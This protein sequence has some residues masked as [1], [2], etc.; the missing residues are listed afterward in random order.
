MSCVMWFFFFNDTATTEIYTLSLP[1]ALPIL[2]VLSEPEDEL[3]RG[4]PLHAGTGADARRYDPSLVER[5][6][7]LPLH[8][9]LDL[10]QPRG[11]TGD[12]GGEDKGGRPLREGLL[13]R[14]RGDDRHRGGGE[15][16]EGR[17]GI[18]RRG[19]WPR[20]H[21]AERRPGRED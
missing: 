13:Y 17:A 5:R 19:L 12:S 3:V 7:A 20:R 15:H 14:L 4:D 10:R 16:R 21:R 8:G 18:E 1:D 2:R 6:A 9:H 11:A